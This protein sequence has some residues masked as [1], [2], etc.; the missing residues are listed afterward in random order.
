MEIQKLSTKVQGITTIPLEVLLILKQAAEIERRNSVKGQKDSIDI[1]TILIHGGIELN[2]YLELLEKYNLRF[3]VNE[4][5]YVIKNF[6]TKHI[7]YFDINLKKFVD[8]KKNYL[9]RL[10]ALR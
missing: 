2:K 8:W 1:I 6:N 7:D 10:K 5:I 4:I 3:Y 9:E